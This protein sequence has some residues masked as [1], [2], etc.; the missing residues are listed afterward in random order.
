MNIYISCFC[1]CAWAQMNMTFRIEI[2]FFTYQ[3][4]SNLVKVFIAE[5]LAKCSGSGSS[6]GTN[7]LSH[8][9]VFQI[10]FH[11]HSHAKN[12]HL[13]VLIDD[14]IYKCQ[15]FHS[16]AFCFSEFRVIKIE[17]VNIYYVMKMDLCS[18]TLSFAL[19]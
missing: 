11:S 16:Q 9:N 4:L 12:I 1:S 14:D 2:I 7:T 18:Y 19:I 5:C 8:A 13:K 15:R 17:Y 10:V 6:F 3:N